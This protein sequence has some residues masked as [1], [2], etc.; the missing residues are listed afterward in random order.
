[1][2]NTG[3]SAVGYY[4]VMLSIAAS[5]C[6]I[7]G[8]YMPYWIVG[9]I[10]IGGDKHIVYF[11]SFRRCNYPVFDSKLSQFKI[12]ERCARY[13]TW[14]DI[15]SVY[16]QIATVTIAI[17]CVLTAILTLL[18]I[19][20][21]C[22]KHVI[23]KNSAI[24]AGLMQ[25]V[26]AIFVSAGCLVYPLGWENRQVKDACGELS[27]KYLLGNCQIGWAL[28]CMLVGAALL[29]TCG[30]MSV[31]A[32]RNPDPPPQFTS[33]RNRFRPEGIGQPPSRYSFDAETLIDHNL[34]RH[35]VAT[36][37][38]RTSTQRLMRPLNPPMPIAEL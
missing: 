15:P 14:D 9:G 36:T 10:D 7:V 4:W 38:R 20:A 31:C 37:G 2:V 18:M 27:G 17:G 35:S 3:L 24:L 29:L 1:M 25:A 5:A 16:W 26:A 8:F 11:G 19:P 32:G 6:I 22:V 33:Y 13:A 28:I 21:C 30:A 12:D 34:R 23:T